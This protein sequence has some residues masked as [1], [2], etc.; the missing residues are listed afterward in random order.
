V[1]S[2]LVNSVGQKTIRS[3]DYTTLFEG[4]TV[5]FNGCVV[6]LL[7][8]QVT[9]WTRGSTDVD[10]VFERSTIPL[11]DINPVSIKVTLKKGGGGIERDGYYVYFE[12]RNNMETVK[13]KLR[14]KEDSY[15]GGSIYLGDEEKAN[16]AAKALSQ[17]VKACQKNQ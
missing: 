11:S 6:S 12:T 2:D 5:V 10:S 16:Q 14:D 3:S 1:L 8:R 13:I 17:V 4:A 7:E 15:A 9:T